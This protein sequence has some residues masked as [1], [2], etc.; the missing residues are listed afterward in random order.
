[1]SSN[2]RYKPIYKRLLKLQFSNFNLKK[3]NKLKKSKWSDF[4][5][6][7]KRLNLRRKCGLFFFDHE[8]Y[9]KPKYLF[10]LKKNYKT[11][12]ISKQKFSHFYG[13]L[14][15]RY[16]KFIVSKSLKNK[17]INT[18][19]FLIRTLES[20]LDIL[21]FRAGFAKSIREARQFIL[22]GHIFVNGIK[23]TYYRYILKKGDLIEISDE[24]NDIVRTN[25]LNCSFYPLPPNYLQ[26]NYKTNQIVFIQ[27]PSS[28][29]VLSQYNFFI[30]FNNILSYFKN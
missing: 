17:K 25:L 21:L 7:I 22:H 29:L 3:L 6:K 5:L 30:N 10:R 28:N 18:Q 1:M 20:R 16:L 27:N 4:S 23:Q 15:T 26:I 13:N 8:I 24:R 9:N 2:K 14:L 12:L 11:N 19:D